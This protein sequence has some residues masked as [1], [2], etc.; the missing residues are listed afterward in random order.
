MIREKVGV[1]S[2]WQGLYQVPVL[3]NPLPQQN[4]ESL[5]RTML[6]RHDPAE[7]E[8][9]YILAVMLERKR[10]LKH[11]ETQ[12][13]S[14][15]LSE[16]PTRQKKM[17]VYEHHCTGEVFMIVDPELRLDQLNEVQRRVSDL[18]MPTS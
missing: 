13:S 17:L 7:C 16:T 11:R 8:A 4:A 18:L 3:T 2:H 5:F 9:L 12:L 1:V 15:A 10:I 6:E 14:E